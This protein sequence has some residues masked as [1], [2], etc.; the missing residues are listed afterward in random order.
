MHVGQEGTDW[1]N[2]ACGSCPQREL[3]AYDT[4]EL[5]DTSE[6]L[7][8]E[9][10]KGFVNV[11]KRTL[12]CCRDSVLCGSSDVVVVVI[13]RVPIDAVRLK[14]WVEVSS[15]ICHVREVLLD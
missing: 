1:V 5:G 14:I 3:N 9:H 11:V 13:G 10:T 6:L 4:V 8:D 15:T 7:L 2:H 12:C